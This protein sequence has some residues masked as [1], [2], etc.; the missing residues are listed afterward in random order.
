MDFKINFYE[1]SLVILKVTSDYFFIMTNKTILLIIFSGIFLFACQNNQKEKKSENFETITTPTGKWQLVWD[2]EFDYTGLPDSTKWS[3]DTK[4]NEWGWGNNE[5]Q[6]Y[7]AGDSSNAY[8]SE[9]FL[10][11]TAKI[12]SMGGKKYTSAR[13]ITKD[14]GDWLYGRF[15]IKAKL[16]T[17]LGTWPA[18]WMLSTD[19]EYGNWPASGEIDI[20]EN[21]GY[22]PDT[23]IG[24]VHTESY[25]HMIGTQKTDS[26]YIPT[27]FTDFHVYSLEWEENEIRLYVDDANYFTFNNEGKSFKEW[28]FDKRFHLLLNLAIGGNWGGKKGVDDSL[29]PHKFLIDYVRVYKKSE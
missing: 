3:Y 12:D 13:L 7:T 10:T 5:A 26:I 6:F 15:E 8:V 19:W 11:I 14:K 1:K 28:P 27:N 22:I 24:T 17:G 25:N 2:E 29:F 23:I 20:M 4:G 9:G 18:I 16:P 21:V